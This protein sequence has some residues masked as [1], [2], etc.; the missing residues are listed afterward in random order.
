MK[1]IVLLIGL[2]MFFAASCKTTGP[3]K[4]VPEDQKVADASTDKKTEKKPATKKA[5]EKAPATK[6]TPEKKA[7]EKKTPAKPAKPEKTEKKKG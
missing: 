6:K 7:P 3:K 2:L 4:N 5:T 1:R